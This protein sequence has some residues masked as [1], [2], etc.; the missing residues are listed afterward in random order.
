MKKLS[1]EYTH[2]WPGIRVPDELLTDG[3][4]FFSFEYRDVIVGVHRNTET[5]WRNRPKTTTV[6][7]NQ[8]AFRVDT[9]EYQLRLASAQDLRDYVPLVEWIEQHGTP[10]HDETPT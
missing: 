8:D 6:Y 4:D 3:E 9:V 10:V 2:I 1:A 5:F 7:L